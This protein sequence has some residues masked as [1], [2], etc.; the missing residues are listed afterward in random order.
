MKARVLV[1]A[2]VGILVCLSGRPAAAQVRWEAGFKGGV[3]LGKLTGD[4]GFSVSFTDGVDTFAF[5]GDISDYRTGFVGGGFATGN[6]S[7]AFGIRLEVLYA[8]K[9]GTGSVVVTFNGAPAGSADITFKLDYLEIP[10]LGVASFPAGSATKMN[11]LGGPVVAFNTSAK[12]K[13]ESQGQSNEQDISDVE[14]TDFGFAVGAGV[15]RPRFTRILTSTRR[16]C[17]R[18]SRVL[19]SAIG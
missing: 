12:L 4:T 17:S 5:S 6:F 9:G 2:L 3:G 1:I 8:Q 18:P 16:F 11:V 15:V 7:D 19:L 10:I 13:A 14:S